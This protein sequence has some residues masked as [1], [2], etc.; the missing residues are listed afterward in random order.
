M[1]AWVPGKY[2]E[3]VLRFALGVEPHDAAR[4]QR[5]AHPLEVAMDGVPLPVPST[6]RD[7]KWGPFEEHDLLPRAAR[8]SS[9][10]HVFLW[11]DSTRT[12]M[13]VRVLDPRQ[14][15]VPRRLRVLL[16]DPPLPGRAVAPWLYPGAAY[17]VS[18]AVSGIR[19]IVARDGA[20]M[21]WA[22]VRA[23]RVAD[24]VEVGRAHGD[25]R[26]EFLLL[27]DPA[28]VNAGELTL[29]VSVRVVVF[30]P[31]DRP[32]PAADPASAVDPLW[33]LPLETLPLPADEDGTSSGDR[34]PDG[35][36]STANSDKEVELVLG[37]F[38]SQTFDFS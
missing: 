5:V 28:M 9:S 27:P 38:R 14:R 26:G 2:V 19:G 12:E 7:P 31:T 6:L 11:K 15:F 30:G 25:A 17:D 21:R 18:D 16:T 4:R 33:D 1:N 29:P 23:L 34:L 22:R 37:R 32:D 3:Q 35:Y 13:A 24:G 10:R 8:H 36:V 20:P